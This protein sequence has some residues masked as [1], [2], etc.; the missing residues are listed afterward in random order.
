M[1]ITTSITER[2]T[3]VKMNIAM[4]C[5]RVKRDP[6]EVRIVG[7]TKTHPAAVV[8]ETLDAGLLDFGENRTQELLPKAAE[9]EAMGFTPRWHFVGHLQR[10]KVS[11]VL[12]RISTLHSLDSIRLANEIE[13]RSELLNRL[14]KTEAPP[15]ALACYLEVNVSGEVS[16][17][18]VKPRQI[19]E[20]LQELNRYR[21]IEIVGLMTVA[22]FVR[23]PEEVRP[24]FRRLNEL[25]DT[26]G[27]N[28][29]SMGMTDD[30]VVAIEE[31]ATIVRLG[32]VLF[33]VRD[34]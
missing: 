1:A 10:N 13:H 12:T 21:Y 19:S 25:A 8:K 3:A 34:Y 31:G 26:H 17:E 7:V 15:E 30:Y 27:L 22:P 32:R 6:S 2:L 11:Q 9:I 14:S 23:D 33:G 28:G 4:A 24:V 16:K 5:E 18:G 29:L 20:L